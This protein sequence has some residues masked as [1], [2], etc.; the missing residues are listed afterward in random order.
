M[1]KARDLARLS[2]DSSGKI[3]L[4]SGVSGV[5]PDANAPSGSVIQVVTVFKND[6]F[7]ST[8]SSPTWTDVTGLSVSITPTSA[9]STILVLCAINVGSNVDSLIRLVRDSTLVGNGTGGTIQGIGQTAP[10]PNNNL[11]YQPFCFS[12]AFIDS[13]AKTT[14]T[15]YK[16][17]GTNSGSGTLWINRR[18]IEGSFVVPSSIT[19]MEIAA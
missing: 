4:A 13:P 9:S 18:S 8:S 15:T 7:S 12:T 5:L 6:T 16:I 14:A 17:Q 3:A 10:G 19:V 1:G 2:P 11:M